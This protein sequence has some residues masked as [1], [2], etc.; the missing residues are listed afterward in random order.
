MDNPPFSLI[1]KIIDFYQERNVP[2]FL[3]CPGLTFFST[4]VGRPE[5]TGVIIE[6]NVVY[7][8]GASV[9][10]C[11]LTNLDDVN[12]IRTA[13]DLNR[14]I[15]EIQESDKA[16]LPKYAYPNEVVNANRLK[17][18]VRAGVKF[19]IPKNG[20][21]MIRRLD[22]QRPIKKAIFGA[23]MLI[24]SE[25]AQEF[26]AAERAAAERAA[27]ERAAA[28]RAAAERAHV[29]ELSESERAIINK[30]Q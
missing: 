4:M 3:F 16:S 18:L 8:N 14:K 19:E 1:S 12:V 15:K 21:H 25:R 5:I 2:F 10:T 24:N 17:K 13:P 11:F 23:G 22:A 9:P 27:A 6:T 29:F 7:D 30:L 26:A 28:E 20:C